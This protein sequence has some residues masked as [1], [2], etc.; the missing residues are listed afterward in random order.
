MEKLVNGVNGFIY[1]YKQL[2]CSEAELRELAS[3]YPTPFHLYDKQ[4]IV[5]GAKIFNESFAWT[6]SL[7]GVAFKNHFAVKSTPTPKIVKILHEECDM[8]VDCS[9]LGELLLCEKLGIKGEDIMFTSNN[10]HFEEYRKAFQLGAI[11]N[12]DDFSQIDNL[13]KALGGTMP[14]LVAFRFNP[15]ADH[16][17]GNN[18]ILGDPVEAKFGLTKSQLFAAYKKCKEYGV[19]RFGLHTMV[20][21]N[22]LDVLDLANTARMLFEL[23]VEIYQQTGISV[24]F[25]NMGGG[26]GVQYSPE[27]NSVDLADLGS[28]VKA[29]YEEIVLPHQGLHPV[30]IKYECGCIV[31]AEHAC[32]V[33]RVI[34]MKDTYKR[35]LGLD[36]T[37]ADL[38]LE[39][40]FEDYRAITIVKDQSL[41]S[42]LR[43]NLPDYKTVINDPSY[44]SPLYQGNKKERMFDIVGSLCQNKD[45]FAVDRVLNV[46]PEIGDLCI[47][48]DTGAYGGTSMG[49]NF[50][51]KL[52]HAEILRVA[53]SR[54]EMIRRA[55]TYDD[56]FA[57]M[58]FP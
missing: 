34:N 47:I 1:N 3:F 19:K 50:N 55:E 44:A 12:L 24:E 41:S 8:G 57:T 37:M 25:V 35:F 40:E 56:Y 16:D 43:K 32:L 22:C 2:P 20:V 18:M 45:K 11:I 51:A 39:G 48:H 10:T 23:A 21:C 9:S 13:K 46:N 4:S 33:S 14:D 30:Q 38:V 53:P 42:E 36:A 28:R 27:Q 58:I 7:T 6:R 54:Y 5:R 31:T 26:I 17:I 52:Q 15:G 49:F 29:L